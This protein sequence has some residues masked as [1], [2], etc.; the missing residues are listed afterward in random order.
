MANA[1]AFGVLCVAT[2]WLEVAGRETSLLWVAVILW[3]LFGD[4]DS[5]DCSK[6]GE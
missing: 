4:F 3:A 1:L 5:C 6:A 2:A